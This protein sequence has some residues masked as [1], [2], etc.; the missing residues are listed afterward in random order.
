MYTKSRMVR[1]V[2]PMVWRPVDANETVAELVV[3]STTATEDGQTQAAA[4]S[5]VMI[6]SEPVQSDETGMVMVGSAANEYRVPDACD[7][8]TSGSYTSDRDPTRPFPPL[9]PRPPE[10]PEPPVPPPPTSFVPVPA[11]P[12]EPPAPPAPPVPPLPPAPADPASE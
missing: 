3:S 5:L 11:A 10:E 12:P 8:A 4:S 6:T 1:D 9:P 2:V 7:M